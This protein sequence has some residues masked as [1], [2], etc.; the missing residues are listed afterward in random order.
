MFWI[1]VAIVV[2]CLFQI[3]EITPYLDGG[4]MY[5]ITKQWSD[6]LRTYS[7]GS[8][9]V[10]GKLAF[11]HGG[12]FPEYNTHRLPMANP[13]PPFYHAEYIEKH[14]IAKVSRFFS[15]L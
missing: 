14:E 9:D 11:S 13:P 6:Q 12:L 4:L 5:G 3:N 10:N 8:I 2:A 7:N 1:G 15:N